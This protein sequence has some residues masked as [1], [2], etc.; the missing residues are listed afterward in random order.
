MK[1]KKVNAFT[2]SEML[3]VMII[4]SIVIGMTFTALTIVNRYVKG[5]RTNLQHQQEVRLLETTLTRDL[6]RYSGTYNPRDKQITLS[7]PLDTI[8]Y[9]FLDSIITRKTDTF[10]IPIAKKKLFLD[11]KEV[12]HGSIDAIELEVPASYSQQTIFISTTKD[13]SFY[14]NN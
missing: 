8:R 1:I 10:Q 14:L 2:I 4:A 5:I 13:A 11:G 9:T 12:T 3:V 7:F 6:N